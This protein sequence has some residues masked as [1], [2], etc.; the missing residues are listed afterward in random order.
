MLRRRAS[1]VHPPLAGWRRRRSSVVDASRGPR[2][3]RRC[4]PSTGLAATGAGGL[5]R[6]RGVRAGT[7]PADG[8]G[9]ARRRSASRCGCG[10]GALGRRGGRGGA[11]RGRPGRAGGGVGR[12][13]DRRS[14]RAA[15][16]Q[17]TPG[18]SAVGREDGPRRCTRTERGARG[19]L[20]GPL[21]HGRRYHDGATVLRTVADQVGGV[22]RAPRCAARHRSGVTLTIGDAGL[23]VAGDARCAR[24]SSSPTSAT[25]PGPAAPSRSSMARYDG[26]HPV[27]REDAARPRREP[28]RD[29]R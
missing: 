19:R 26:Q 24:S 28:R 6:L 20:R 5:D 21:R 17:P 18:R 14:R 9:S 16:L 25:S 8:R 7:M 3:R 15:S 29:R 10:R 22:P 11:G 4:W 27:D 1:S 13:G 23:G 12:L 2:G